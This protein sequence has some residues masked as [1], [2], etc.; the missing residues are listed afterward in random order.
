MAPPIKR[1]AQKTIK[2]L[3]PNFF[4]KVLNLPWLEGWVL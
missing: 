1:I 4:R 3:K 2:F